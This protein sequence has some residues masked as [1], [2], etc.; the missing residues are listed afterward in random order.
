MGHE[1][2]PDA[3]EPVAAQCTDRALSVQHA[4]YPAQCTK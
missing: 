1:S 4:D 2:D 3:G